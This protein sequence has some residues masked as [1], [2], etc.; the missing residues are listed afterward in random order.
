VKGIQVYSNNGQLLYPK[1]DNSKTTFRHT[2]Q[3]FISKT[4]RPILGELGSN[5]PWNFI[6]LKG[7]LAITLSK[8]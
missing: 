1:A 6:S 5:L 2:F 3:I 4:S 7:Q 8:Y